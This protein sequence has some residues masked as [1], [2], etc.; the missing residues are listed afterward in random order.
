MS[1]VTP[2]CIIHLSDPHCTASS[3]TLGQ[4]SDGILHRDFQNSGAK[5]DRLATYITAN[6]Q[7]LGADT[8]VISGDL[9]DSGDEEDY[10]DPHNGVLQF[11]ARMRNAGF[12][13]FAVPGNH[14]YCKEGN[15]FLTGQINEGEQ[16]RRDRFIRLVTPQYASAPKYPHVEDIKRTDGTLGAHLILL[17]SMQEELD[18]NTGN[19]RAQ[20]T[21]GQ[22]Q[23]DALA[24]KLGQLQAGR[25]QG[26]KVIC[27]LHHS[28]F[29]DSGDLAL[30]DASRF[31]SIITG[32]V[33]CL[34][35]GHV[36]RDNRYQGPRYTS[37]TVYET[38]DASIVQGQTALNVPL[39]NVQN[40]EFMGSTLP[41]SVLDVANST[42]SV[43]YLKPY[44][45]SLHK[46]ICDEPATSFGDDLQ[47]YIDNN[48]LTP[49]ILANINVS[50]GAI[51][52]TLFQ[53][54]ENILAGP[55][56]E[57]KIDKGQTYN[58]TVELGVDDKAT[59]TFMEDGDPAGG[60]VLD[61]KAVAGH[62]EQTLSF[63]IK[64]DGR[65]RLFY[66]VANLVNEYSA[67]AHGAAAIATTY[68]PGGAWTDGS[69]R[70]IK[71]TRIFNALVLDMSAFGRPAA[72]GRI[73]DANT[74]AVT[75]PDGGAFTARMTA[76][77]TLAWSN[78]SSWKKRPSIATVLD[79]AG[80]WTDGSTRSIPITRS[81]DD[82]ALDMSAFGRPAANGKVTGP[83]AISV[84][85]PDAGTFAGQL[86][87]PNAIHWS[88]N[89]SWTKRPT[90]VVN[91]G[92]VQ[93]G[94]QLNLGDLKPTPETPPP[95]RT[96]GPVLRPR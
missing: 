41:I 6:R 90:R 33:D 62:G 25:A 93:V 27:A 4:I 34:I 91:V 57:M 88:N 43:Y 21:L 68:D 65:Y 19:N 17:D 75:F 52:D 18:G 73:V 92:D 61:A 67:G 86:V 60:A 82:L 5:L 12:T 84:N 47:I 72:Y 10:S 2:L 7:T 14:D 51:P 23:L 70:D 39:I 66:S 38:E 64:D 54:A 20:G 59:L 74:I 87:A 28:P 50:A 48:P 3:H 45:L 78:N 56:D 13:V 94:H 49:A 8:I 16:A 89:S 46:V 95:I 37:P 9:T 36:T 32:Q 80:A 71:V 55:R 79:L 58:L 76:A 77:D 29:Y 11:I 83:A 81:G 31:K 26:V 96:E 30:S 42:R 69:N 40:L 15:Q 24:T 44:V 85:F 53:E 35:Y 1:G 63:K 22:T